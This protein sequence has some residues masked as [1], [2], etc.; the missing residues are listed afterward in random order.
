MVGVIC[1][2]E[3]LNGSGTRK[4]DLLKKVQKFAKDFDKRFSRGLT[5][6]MQIDNE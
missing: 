3:C 1:D 2:E 4:H 6:F 5:D